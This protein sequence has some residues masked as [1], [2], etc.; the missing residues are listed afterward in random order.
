MKEEMYMVV[1]TITPA[2]AA[3]YLRLNVKNRKL[4]K[5]KVREYTRDIKS[6]KWQLSPEGISF[7]KNGTLCNGQHRLNAIISANIPV[8]MAVTYNVPN[9]TVMIDKNIAR[10]TK[11]IMDME[12]YPPEISNKTIVGAIGFL[13]YEA[14]EH[15]INNI[16]DAQK[17]LFVEEYFKT[18]SLVREIV[19]SGAKGGGHGNKGMCDNAITAAACFCALYE[20]ITK[21]VLTQFFTVVNS[22]FYSFQEETAAI[23]LRNYMVANKGKAVTSAD[24]AALF[25]QILS[26]INCYINHT[27]R[28]KYFPVME[29]PYYFTN[30]KNHIKKY[31]LE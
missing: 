19:R 26:A 23:V 4:S 6:G 13:F 7:Y 29:T 17:M 1:E 30:I 22:G 27:P 5:K 25:S 2:K 15:H 28:Q 21:E 20:G 31:Y 16:S 24:K 10:T 18:L 12:G 8:K 14:T 11:N 9:D 3:E